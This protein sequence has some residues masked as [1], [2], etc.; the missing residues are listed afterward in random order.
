MTK[1]KRLK[2]SA[3][4]RR[5]LRCTKKKGEIK[6]RKRTIDKRLPRKHGMME[7]GMERGNVPKRWEMGVG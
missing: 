4:R 6:R 3:K 1:W 5:A 7:E 2:I